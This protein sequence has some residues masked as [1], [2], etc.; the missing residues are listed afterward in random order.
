MKTKQIFIFSESEDIEPIIKEIESSYPIHYFLA[1]LFDS[2][3][4]VHYSSILQSPNLGYVS[5]GDW[6]HNASYLVVPK[7]KYIKVRS[8]PQRKGGVKFAI[9]Q[10]ENPESCVLKLSGIY[11]GEI[12]V[13]GSLGTISSSDFSIDFMN[14]FRRLLKKHFDKLG[15]FY[16]GKAA[17]QKLDT[18]WRLV[19]NDKSP[20][21]YDLKA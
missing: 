9:D 3:Q 18:G 8:V 5:N 21:E 10:M 6:N 14:A 15:E 11:S 4:P 12:L 17:R 7:D 1:G 13:G 16:V 20:V 2:D 19:T